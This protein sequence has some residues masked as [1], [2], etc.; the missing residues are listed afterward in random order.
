MMGPQLQPTITYGEI[1]AG[2]MAAFTV[3]GVAWR[4]SLRFS[5]I[6]AR[7]GDLWAEFLARRQH[8]H[9]SSTGKSTGS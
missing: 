2:L 6:E 9:S 4:F 8:A 7:V 1:L 3:L 5:V